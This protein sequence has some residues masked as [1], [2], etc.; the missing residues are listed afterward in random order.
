MAKMRASS[1]TPQ[2]PDKDVL[3]KLIRNEGHHASL[4]RCSQNRRLGRGSKING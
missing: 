2:F 1:K 3:R 4:Y